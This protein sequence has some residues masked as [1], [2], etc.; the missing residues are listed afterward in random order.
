MFLLW[1]CCIESLFFFLTSLFCSFFFVFPS[2][3][4][5]RCCFLWQSCTAV[6]YWYISATLD[7][8]KTLGGTM[9]EAGEF[10]DMFNLVYKY[11]WIDYLFSVNMIFVFLKMLKYVRLSPKLSIVS[12]T[13][14]STIASSAG[15]FVIFLMLLA[16]YA[17]A[18]WFTY[19][20]MI[21]EFR[22]LWNSFVSCSY[23]TTTHDEQSLCTLHTSCD[24]VGVVVFNLTLFFPCIFL[25]NNNKD[26]MLVRFGGGG[27]R[28]F[29]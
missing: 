17:L 10:V 18:F 5:S 2:F 29:F 28:C 23:A 26:D 3:S 27:I 19:G 14:T 12:E 8:E 20:Q 24:D 16:S 15:F 9:A 6:T 7:A 21:F 13:L 1:C 25:D 22:T 4:L 11:R